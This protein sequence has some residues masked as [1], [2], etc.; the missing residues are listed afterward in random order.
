MTPWPQ[1]DFAV[2]TNSRLGAR[3]AAVLLEV[4]LA[5]A[6]FVF[7][8][9]VIASGLHAAL[10]RVEGLRRECHAANL[11]ATVMAEIQLGIRPLQNSGREPLPE[12]FTDWTAQVESAPYTFGWEDVAGLEQV[13]VVVRHEVS[14]TSSR[15]CTLT[16]ATP[17][18]EATTPADQTDE[19][20]PTDT[21]SPGR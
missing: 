10:N 9:A 4:I 8:A 5:L 20:F 11:A 12:P 7:A 6:L 13:T 19:M 14:G 16:P 1:R 2:S 17:L 3:R 18:R 21:I 15:L